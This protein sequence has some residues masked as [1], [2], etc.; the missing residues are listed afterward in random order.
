MV[1]L[2]SQPKAKHLAPKLLSD[3]NLNVFSAIAPAC[4]AQDF[5][6]TQSVLIA[7]RLSFIFNFKDFGEIVN[8][9]NLIAF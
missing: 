5:T 6:P 8:A 9:K 3:V 2:A 7:N 4:K 1:R